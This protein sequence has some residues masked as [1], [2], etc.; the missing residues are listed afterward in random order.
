MKKKKKASEYAYP[1]LIIE[2][3]KK[4]DSFEHLAQILGLTQT[5]IINKV[6][7]RTKFKLLETEKICSYYKKDYEELFKGE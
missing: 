5:T 6:Y 7:G 2:M 1:N 4:G 3:D